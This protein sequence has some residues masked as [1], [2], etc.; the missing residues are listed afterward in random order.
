MLVCKPDCPDRKPGCQGKC[1]T[2]LRF[3][4]ELNKKSQTIRRKKAEIQL[5][6]G[7]SIQ[8]YDIQLFHAG[9]KGK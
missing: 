8:P 9:G 4:A 6:Y 3:R 5:A 1:E 2:Y 7:Y